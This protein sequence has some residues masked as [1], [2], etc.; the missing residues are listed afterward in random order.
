MGELNHFLNDNDGYSG[1]YYNT[2][3]LVSKGIM[4]RTAKCADRFIEQFMKFIEDNKIEK[5]RS[6]EEY[7]IEFILIGVIFQEYVD[8]AR[9]LKK[10]PAEAIILINNY[11]DKKESRKEKF[12]NIMEWMS[13]K[14][15]FKTKNEGDEYYYQDF[16]SII[17]WLKISSEFKEEVLRL[18]NWKKFLKKNNEICVNHLL[19]QA[20]DI[21]LEL[22]EV[23]V[24][25][26]DE[27][28]DHLKKSKLEKLELNNHKETYIYIHRGKI[29]YYFNMISSQIMNEVYMEK[30]IE[31][32]EKII[33][34]PKSMKQTMIKCCCVKTNNGYKCKKCNSSCKVKKLNIIGQEMGVRVYSKEYD[35]PIFQVQDGYKGTIGIIG[36]TCSL[37]LMSI[38]WKA[39]RVGYYPQSFLLENC[40]NIVNSMDFNQMKNTDAY[41]II[42]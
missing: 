21:S 6:K 14:I 15:S 5:I 26:L 39:I 31:C 20:I 17:R 16:L 7:L 27:Y 8:N 9:A 38:G 32:S 34:V 22:N 41:K 3:K 36:V 10:I 13:T 4:D 11:K 1:K 25:F 12:S 42:S 19:G 37:K 29:Q 33:Q 30:Y 24:K 40:K 28:V 23:G 18:E 35:E 2:L